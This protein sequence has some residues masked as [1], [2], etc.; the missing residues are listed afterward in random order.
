MRVAISATG[1]SPESLVHR[2]FGRCEWFIIFDETHQPAKVIKNI[3]TEASTGAGIGCAQDLI[4]EGVEAVIS[5]QFGPK[6]YEVFKQAGVEMY[7]VQPNISTQEAYNRYL[8]HNLEK[9]EVRKF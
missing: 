4:Q 5:G 6:A 9:M 8:S 7:L 3:H 2:L 1:D